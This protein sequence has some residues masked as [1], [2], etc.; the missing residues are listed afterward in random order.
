MGFS[1]LI[2]GHRRFW[3]VL[4]FP[5]NYWN[6]GNYLWF[7]SVI[8]YG[9][10][11]IL[12]FWM[13]CGASYKVFFFVGISLTAAFCVTFQ[14]L[15]LDKLCEIRE[16]FKVHSTFSAPQASEWHKRLTVPLFLADQ[17]FLIWLLMMWWHPAWIFGQ[18]L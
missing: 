12:C 3:F 4:K 2:F 6:W 16:F 14:S 13:G 15:R 17:Y 1:D 18:L 7:A 11:Y 8:V 10:D 9:V 5:N